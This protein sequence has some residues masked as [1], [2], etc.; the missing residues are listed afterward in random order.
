VLRP[1]PGNQRHRTDSELTISIRSRE[2]SFGLLADWIVPEMCGE[3]KIARIGTLSHQRLEE[4]LKLAI[5]AWEVVGIVLRSSTGR[6][7]RRHDVDPVP[8]PVRPDHDL[9]CDEDLVL[10]DQISGM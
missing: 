3:S 6:K 5:V 1:A 4:N 10:R 8:S 2:T 7:T 9:G